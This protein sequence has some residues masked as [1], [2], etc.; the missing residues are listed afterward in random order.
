MH[1]AHTLDTTDTPAAPAPD[2]PVFDSYDTS[3]PSGF[4]YASDASDA[5]NTSDA[6]DSSV[7]PAVASIRDSSPESASLLQCRYYNEKGFMNSVAAARQAIYKSENSNAEAPSGSIAGGI[8]PHHLLA[9]KMIAEFFQYMSGSSP[10]TIIVLAPNHRKI[11]LSGIHTSTLSWGTAFGTLESDQE[12]ARLIINKMKAAENISL[13]EEEHSISS[14]VPYIKYYMPDSKIV[15]VLL[16]GNYQASD[17]LA[18]L[19]ADMLSKNTRITI[20]ASVD[21]SHYLDSET[22]DKMD[23]ETLAAIKTGDIEK[24]SKMSNDNL[25]SPPS[26]ITLINIMNEIDA[27]LSKVLDHGNSSDITG[28]GANYTTS[29]YSIIYKR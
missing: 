6:P 28:T 24:I 14:L 15:P 1:Y 5:Y 4:S 9:G 23:M 8:V 18:E 12:I 3:D 29:Y 13:M 7:K 27:K 22:A 10:D 19:L 26:I 2:A 25:D 21:F 16:H 11:G 17:K 20:V